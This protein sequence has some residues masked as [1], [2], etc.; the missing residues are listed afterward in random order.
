MR[1][2]GGRVKKREETVK[3]MRWRGGDKNRGAGWEEKGALWKESVKQPSQR[4]VSASVTQIR[5]L[6]QDP[7]SSWMFDYA[8]NNSCIYT[9]HFLNYNSTATGDAVEKKKKK[10][11]WEAEIDLRILTSVERR[12]L[13][14]YRLDSAECFTVQMYSTQ[15][16]IL[17]NDLGI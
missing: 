11:W 14:L 9:Q 8:S 1:E 4:L 5:S 13:S 3:V 10:N 17:T 7:S 12:D 15:T 2:K 6:S 16:H